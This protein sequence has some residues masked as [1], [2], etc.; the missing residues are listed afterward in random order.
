MHPFLHEYSCAADEP[1]CLKPLHLEHEV[2]DFLEY[3]LKDLIVGECVA[4]AEEQPRIHMQMS[5]YSSLMEIVKELNNS[6]SEKVPQSVEDGTSCIT[7][8]VSSENDRESGDVG[9][10]KVL[11]VLKEEHTSSSDSNGVPFYE[12]GINEEPL[13]SDHPTFSSLKW[14]NERHKFGHRRHHSHHRK[15][16]GGDESSRSRKRKISPGNKIHKSPNFER[17]ILSS[18]VPEGQAPGSLSP[19]LSSSNESRLSPGKLSVGESESTGLGAKLGADEEFQDVKV[20]EL[21]SESSQ[22]IADHFLDKPTLSDELNVNASK[23]LDL[24]QPSLPDS[25]QSSSEEDK[26]ENSKDD[27]EYSATDST[28]VAEVIRRSREILGE[29]SSSVDVAKEKPLFNAGPNELISKSNQLI[30]EHSLE[31][32]ALSNELD[33]NTSETI[34]QPNSVLDLGCLQNEE[35]KHSGLGDSKNDVEYSAT[36]DISAVAEVIRRSRELLGELSS[37]VDVAKEKTLHDGDPGDPVKDL[38][39]KSEQL[40]CSGEKNIGKETADKQEQ[41][42]VNHTQAP[43]PPPPPLQQPESAPNHTLE[44]MLSDPFHLRESNRR[45]QELFQESHTLLGKLRHDPEVSTSSET[46]FL[47]PSET[48]GRLYGAL[49]PPEDKFVGVRTFGVQS[50]SGKHNPNRV[51]KRTE[52]NSCSG[53]ETQFPSTLSTFHDR[54]QKSTLPHTARDRICAFEDEIDVDEMSSVLAEAKRFLGEE[55]D[56]RDDSNQT[57]IPRL[58]NTG[59]AVKANVGEPEYNQSPYGDVGSASGTASAKLDRVTPID[60]L[61]TVNTFDTES[62]TSRP[63]RGIEKIK[64]TVDDEKIID[65]PEVPCLTTIVISEYEN[66][67]SFCRVFKQD[68]TVSVV[69][70]AVILEPV[71]VSYTV[72]PLNETLVTNTVIRN[73][74]SYCRNHDAVTTLANYSGFIGFVDIPTGTAVTDGIHD[75]EGPLGDTTDR[76]GVIIEDKKDEGGKYV[77]IEAHCIEMRSS[78]KNGHCL[79]IANEADLSERTSEFPM[80]QKA[81]G[82]SIGTCHNGT[83]SSNAITSKLSS[84]NFVDKIYRSNGLAEKNAKG[85]SGGLH[86]KDG[87]GKTSTER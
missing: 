13:I 26:L 2:D 65:K 28:T 9:R 39:L 71:P 1:V 23:T 51:S 77:R 21:I 58:D 20:K 12:D 34:E 60:S 53:C 37:S 50:E 66:A 6:P 83:E 57:H 70:K 87:A 52:Q 5:S 17:E 84:E 79:K 36:V 8:K 22:L 80:D 63:N 72:R 67:L 25:E 64:E 24:E 31:K 16:S 41:V 27:V 3:T 62:M 76:E 30:A 47:E 68:D 10:F 69:K 49:P 86:A 15:K 33:A 85:S 40:L 29:L 19:N 32:S 18:S 46:T 61:G 4:L 55:G 45:M 81:F 14:E 11:E 35:D 54:P 48:S 42:P 73:R 7:I 78:P 82:T 59:P 56:S 75:A 74:N 38:I 44:P 43:P